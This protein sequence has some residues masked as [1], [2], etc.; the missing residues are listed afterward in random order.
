LL[1]GRLWTQGCAISTKYGVVNTD[2]IL[3]IASGAFHSCKPS[4]MLAELQGRLPIK[5]GHRRRAQRTC[6][7]GV[8]GVSR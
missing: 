4:D 8:L 6:V 1:C 3:F 7:L 2:Q 5:V